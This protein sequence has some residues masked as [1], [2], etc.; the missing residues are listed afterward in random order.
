MFPFNWL[1]KKFASGGAEVNID[2]V[3]GERCRVFERIDNEAGC[4]LVEI[5]GSVWSA[6]GVGEEDS[7]EV[8]EE[9]VVVAA[10]GVKLVCRKR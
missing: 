3:I 2:N 4:G 6:R 8:G 7:F 9:L 10:E 5:K 1:K